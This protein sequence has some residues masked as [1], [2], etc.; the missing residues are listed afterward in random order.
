[1][2]SRRIRTVQLPWTSVT[3]NPI[4]VFGCYDWGRSLIIGTG[5]VYYDGENLLRPDLVD[6]SGNPLP[7]DTFYNIVIKGEPVLAV[8]AKTV[9]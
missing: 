7:G 3:Y 9:Q 4:D 2:S 1:M 6:L 8:L 5:L